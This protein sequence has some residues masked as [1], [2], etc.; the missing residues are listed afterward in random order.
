MA[1]SGRLGDCMQSVMKGNRRQSRSVPK[2]LCGQFRREL[3]M[4]ERQCLGPQRQAT[5]HVVTSRL[6]VVHVVHPSF[7]RADKAAA[8]AELAERKRVGGP[9]VVFM[10]LVWILRARD[11]EVPGSREPV[12]SGR[13]YSI[14]GGN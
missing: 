2:R 10:D 4:R 6:A 11:P 14:P 12:P 7:L 8:A 5:Y 13:L 1:G 9:Q 3:G